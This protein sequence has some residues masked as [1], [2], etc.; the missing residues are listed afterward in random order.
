MSSKGTC[1]L[2]IAL[3]DGCSSFSFGRRKT[4]DFAFDDEHLSGMH[5]RIFL[6][7]GQFVLEDLHSTNGYLAAKSEPGYD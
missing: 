7:H 1:E 6:L 5:A 3:Q 4:N 2:T